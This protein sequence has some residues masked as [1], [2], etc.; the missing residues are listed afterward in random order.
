VLPWQH[1]ADAC[2]GQECLSL[3]ERPL[4]ASQQLLVERGLMC[5]GK[6]VGLVQP[7][8]VALCLVPIDGVD[9]RVAEFGGEAQA[10]LMHLG[11]GQGEVAGAV[12]PIL[13]VERLVLVRDHF[14]RHLRGMEALEALHA[15]ADFPL[16]PR[17]EQI[18]HL[19]VED[20]PAGIGHVERA[21]WQDNR[22]VD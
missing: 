6:R 20:I 18:V 2:A 10:E 22:L 15:L 5:L 11:P 1:L 14:Q 17:R 7:A 21:E 19:Y 13:L 16:P 3:G 8:R 4:A 9:P 12:A